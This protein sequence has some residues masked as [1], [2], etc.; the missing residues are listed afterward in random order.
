VKRRETSY[1]KGDSRR[2]NF[3]KF[4]EG[5]DNIRRED[6]QKAKRRKVRPSRTS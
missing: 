2:D 4:Q 1:S 5:Y 3:K 6:G